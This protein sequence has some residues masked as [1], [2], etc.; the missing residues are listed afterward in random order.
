MGT[1]VSRVAP[2]ELLAPAAGGA[3]M[4]RAAGAGLALG[5]GWGVLARV[6]MRM[7][8]TSPEFSWPGTLLIIAFSALAGLALGLVH[9]A[10]ARNRSRWW[11]LVVVLAL[12]IVSASQGLVFAPAF[13]LGGFA[14]AGRGPRVVRV[15]LALVATGPIWLIWATSD[16]VERSLV[17]APTFVVGLL[18]LMTGVAW[19]GSQ[20]FRRWPRRALVAHPVRVA[21]SA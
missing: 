7:I 1:N 21:T 14:F 18:V 12:P 10:R 17:P 11:R 15:V 2:A 6:W 16:P 5:A 9:G 20:L 3:V 8:S 19:G 4:V 13:W